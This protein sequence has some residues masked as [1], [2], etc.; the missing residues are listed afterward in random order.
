MRA[1]HRELTPVNQRRSVWRVRLISL[2]VVGASLGA[3]LSS[4][5]A[6]ATRGF[7]R[8]AARP[9]IA[10]GANTP[11]EFSTV[12]RTSGLRKPR[13]LHGGV[14]LGAWTDLPG[15][16][17]SSSLALR[18]RQLGRAYRIVHHYY[19]WGD[20]FPTTSE[21]REASRGQVPMFSW[22]GVSYASI[23]NGSQDRW[24]RAK[25]LAFRRF[26]KPAF[27]RW[28]WEMNGNW[29]DWD[30]VH[31]G[32]STAHFV[33]A[34]RR[35]V[36]IFRR[37]GALNV[38]FVWSPNFESQPGLS[39]LHSWNNWRRYYPGDRYVDWVAIDGYNFGQWGWWSPQYLFGRIY[40]DYA[41]RKPIMIAETS[42]TE[43]GGSK[44]AWISSLSRWVAHHRGVRA[45]VWFDT[46]Q[47]IDW[48]VDSS[49]RSF[50]TY[51]AMARS[52]LF[53]G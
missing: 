37:A 9:P 5:P 24:I 53:S 16:S 14:M 21:R 19:S 26:A 41:R 4:G 52:R 2:G 45:V 38:A 40:N 28:A 1:T 27:L 6:D 43:Q 8:V 29:F 15:R 49:A 47:S 11:A 3:V 46:K 35:I 34:W 50:R 39:N 18:Q 33:T 13:A 31:N 25:A 22:N 44:A 20:P 51:R 36:S 17:L 12:V 10:A 32:R 42:S 48:R 30:G 23:N 7:V